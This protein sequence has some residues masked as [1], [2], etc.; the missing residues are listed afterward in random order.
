[1]T[2]IVWLCAL[3][4]LAIL[5]QGRAAAESYPSKPIKIVV[6]YP[7]GGVADQRSRQIAEKLAKAVGQPVIVD[8]RPGASGAIG[9]S[10]VAKAAPDGYT[11]LWGERV[12]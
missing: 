10:I 4:F 11:L 1:M 8:N 2:K 6:P 5:V 12:R 9:A 3:P 7:A